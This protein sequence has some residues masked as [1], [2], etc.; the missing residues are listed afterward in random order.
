METNSSTTK[1]LSAFLN[2]EFALINEE[3][4]G[5]LNESTVLDYLDS[6]G[7]SSR[8]VFAEIDSVGKVTAKSIKLFNFLQ[9]DLFEFS[10]HFINFAQSGA[11]L[12]AGLKIQEPILAICGVLKLIWDFKGASAIKFSDFDAEVLYTLFILG[13]EGKIADIPTKYQELF[14]NKTIEP[15]HLENA[16]NLLDDYHTIERPD[17]ENYR[18]IETIQLRRA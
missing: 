12:F 1:I 16:L 3:Q 17:A 18:L 14:K 15:D 11:A 7:Y 10:K 5:W 6:D 2:E 9:I 8:T 13:N 4:L